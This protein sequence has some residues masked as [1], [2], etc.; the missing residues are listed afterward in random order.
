MAL[1]K[2]DFQ[3]Q[4]SLQKIQSKINI[5]IEC[6]N[7]YARFGGH[8]P[9]DILDDRKIFDHIKSGKY[10]NSLDYL[11]EMNQR[12]LVNKRLQ[13]Y[14]ISSKTLSS[15]DYWLKLEVKYQRDPI[16][17]SNIR[18]IK[19]G[20]LCQADYAHFTSDALFIN[21]EMLHELKQHVKKALAKTDNNETIIT[22]YRRYLTN[23]DLSITNEEKKIADAMHYRLKI[24]CNHYSINH[25][26]SLRFVL[27]ELSKDIPLTK[28]ESA[29]LQTNKKLKEPEEDF[30]LARA[31]AYIIK[32]GDSFQELDFRTT[33]LGQ[34]N[35]INQDKGLCMAPTTLEKYIPT[36][37]YFWHKFIPGYSERYQFMDNKSKIIFNFLILKN[38]N[39]PRFET[40]LKDPQWSFL[41]SLRLTL[42]HEI[43]DYPQKKPHLFSFLYKKRNQ[44][45][46]EWRRLTK[47]QLFY[48]I[49]LQLKF[50]EKL[51]YVDPDDRNQ[52]EDQL[53]DIERCI[54][55]YGLPHSEKKRFQSIKRRLLT[56]QHI[57]TNETFDIAGPLHQLAKNE[58]LNN[59]EYK[60]LISHIEMDDLSV[61][62]HLESILDDHSNYFASIIKKMILRINGLQ[63]QIDGNQP[64][65]ESYCYLSQTASLCAYF[66]NYFK[67]DLISNLSNAL[68]EFLIVH[69][70]N[71]QGLSQQ[72]AEKL[73]K[74][75]K[76]L[77][78]SI[79][80]IC[81]I[82]SSMEQYKD[83]LHRCQDYLSQILHG[84]K[85]LNHADLVRRARLF[86][87][88]SGGNLT[89]AEY[90]DA[91]KE[92]KRAFLI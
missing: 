85:A 44:M 62:D 67:P 13:N 29:F 76:Q 12:A 10:K 46:S 40:E 21:I 36:K 23:L 27:N 54:K 34:F 11:H 60:S 75:L 49:N 14:L 26:N 28:K 73:N 16:V 7:E 87:P 31:Y 68:D 91:P 89:N 78:N 61:I 50:L 43:D 4:G 3:Q 25:Y 17:L 57:N 39:K 74:G 59:K 71:I 41:S 24:A 81:E 84:E 47:Q 38:V 82:D 63:E 72:Q 35:L 32:H 65:Y 88:P 51:S 83:S 22:E 56:Q 18:Q 45:F 33:N 19:A 86:L 58:N 48:T 77:Y 53:S 5:I 9:T 52:L 30:P 8:L 70:R 80:K 69:E 2:Y 92:P 55:T 15:D 42:A 6:I 90:I 20:W 66:S 79:F 37:R 64:F 1:N